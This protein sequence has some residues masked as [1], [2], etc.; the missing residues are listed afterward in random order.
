MHYFFLPQPL[1]VEA[2]KE[3]LDFARKDWPHL[4]VLRLRQGEQFMLCDGHGLEHLCEVRSCEKN[5]LIAHLIDTRQS[6]RE[7]GCKLIL[8]QGL[9]K[10]DKLELII[11]KAVELGSYSIM[12]VMMARSNVRLDEKKSERKQERL[13]EIAKSAAEQSKRGIIPKVTSIYSFESAL[14][15]AKDADIKLIC[16]EEESNRGTLANILPSLK[17]AKKIAVLVGP[18]GG[19]SEAEWQAAKAAGFQSLSLGRRIL[20]TETAGLCLLS[21]L[22]LHLED[23]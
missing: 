3:P 13:Q 8:L 6:N 21:Y 23:A 14:A 2:L 16:Y 12:P 9:P 10:R 11:Q 18:E 17:T 20:R 15:F 19:I 4:F 1:F 7:L 5:N 22:M